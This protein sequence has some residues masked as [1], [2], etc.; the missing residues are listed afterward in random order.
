MRLCSPERTG[1]AT[2]ATTLTIAIM[3]YAASTVTPII[4]GADLEWVLKGI[5]HE[6]PT[7]VTY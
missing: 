7:K 2:L 3:T 1:I 5:E 6:S 4:I